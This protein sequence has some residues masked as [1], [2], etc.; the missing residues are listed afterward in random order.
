MRHTTSPTGHL[1]GNAS[2]DEPPEVSCTREAP[3]RYTTVAATGGA[4][5]LRSVRP[6]S[7]HTSGDRQAGRDEPQ[8]THTGNFCRVAFCACSS[9]VACQHIT[10]PH[11]P[12]TLRLAAPCVL[13]PSKRSP[14]SIS[15]SWC[16]SK[17]TGASMKIA[18]GEPPAGCRATKVV[19]C[20]TRLTLHKC[21]VT[22]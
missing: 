10:T 4:Y 21:S 14:G 1:P 12:W 11:P 2:V 19:C 3:A 15:G 20:V 6:A 22:S 5:R 18:T 9:Q 17:R 8:R 13:L 16:S 7:Q